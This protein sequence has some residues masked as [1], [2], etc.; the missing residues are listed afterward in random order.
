MEELLKFLGLNS[1]QEVDRLI[2]AI[3]LKKENGSHASSLTN[4]DRCYLLYILI[5]SDTNTSYVSDFE[6]LVQYK[7]D[8]DMNIDEL[9]KGYLDLYNFIVDNQD[10]GFIIIQN[11]DNKITDYL[12]RMKRKASCKA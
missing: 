8:K 2:K 6:V 9:K 12:S 10:H 11:P 1:Y 5:L 4:A 3:Q 7:I